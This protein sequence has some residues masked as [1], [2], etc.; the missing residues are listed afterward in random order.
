MNIIVG[1]AGAATKLSNQSY[2]RSFLWHLQQIQMFL[3]LYGYNIEEQSLM[4]RRVEIKNERCQNY[5]HQPKA[6]T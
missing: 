3:R 2:L 6:I 1:A 4:P 5:L